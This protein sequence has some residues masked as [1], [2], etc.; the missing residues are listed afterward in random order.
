MSTF[1]GFESFLIALGTTVPQMQTQFEASMNSYGW[2]TQIRTLNPVAVS[3][4]LTNAANAVDGDMS[5]YAGGSASGNIV[6]QMAANFTPSQMYVF[7]ENGGPSSG[8]GFGSMPGQAPKQI[9]LDYSDDG[10]A[11]TTLQSWTNEINWGPNQGRLYTITGAA[12]HKYWRLSLTNGNGGNVYIHDWSLEDSS[13]NRVGTANYF[14]II[15]P[16]TETIG[17]SNGYEVVRWVFSQ[18]SIQLQ[19]YQM[20]LVDQPQVLCFYNGTAGAVTYSVTLGSTT[21]SY[22]GTAGN[23]AAQ[24]LRGLYEAIRANVSSDFTAWTWTYDRPTPQNSDDANDYIYGWAN[25][26]TN[27]NVAFSKAGAN[28]ISLGTMWKAGVRPGNNPRGDAT[29]LAITLD[30]INGWIYYLQV[31][32][33]GFVI[34]SKTNSAFYGPIGAHYATNS[35]AVAGKPSSAF[36]FMRLRPIE[37]VLGYCNNNTTEDGNAYLCHTYGM[38]PSSGGP[39]DLN[40]PSGNVGDV[41]GGY[42]VR[43]RYIDAQGG[44]S[45]RIWVYTAFYTASGSNFFQGDTT[46]G[47]DF[48]VHRLSPIAPVF[49]NAGVATAGL[50]GNTDFR[51]LSPILE[52]QDWYKYR[53]TATDE[54]LAL[55]ADTVAVTSIGANVASGDASIQVASTSGFQSAGFV[56]LENEIV[57]YTSVDATHFLGCTRGKY[58]TT[59]TAHFSG[60]AVS[61][62]LWMVKINGG[63]LFAG[64]QKPS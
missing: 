62:G 51:A 33:R 12:G 5:T 21:V 8:T 53:G 54:A 4:T 49:A 9:T 19:S 39:G 15:P 36:P 18:T 22:V 27:T 55:V 60:D 10:A 45:S 64:Y 14:D 30:L 16:N 31:C 28:G 58:G 52:I 23:T 61:Q 34:A 48:Q 1:K 41:F 40:A 24:N 42:A 46:T 7:C 2:Q 63:A 35:K 47:N 6:V 43:D 3:G 44:S 20:S 11:W 50:S 56:V 13:K 32:S 29:N 57:Q 37:L 26:T 17:D 25:A 38:A 59:A